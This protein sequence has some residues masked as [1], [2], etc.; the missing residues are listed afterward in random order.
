MGAHSVSYSHGENKEWTCVLRV[1]AEAM[2]DVITMT[3]AW[4]IG[5]VTGH[6]GS[7]SLST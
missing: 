1:L 3:A 4:S 7:A 2:R 5:A 6:C